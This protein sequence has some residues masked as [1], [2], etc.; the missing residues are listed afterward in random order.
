M[1]EKLSRLGD[2]GYGNRICNKCKRK[3]KEQNIA[4]DI[5]NLISTPEWKRQKDIWLDNR[6]K[7]I[8]QPNFKFIKPKF[9]VI[10]GKRVRLN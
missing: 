8:D 3:E 7:G 1:S 9:R 6:A 5:S 10:N 4:V 2:K